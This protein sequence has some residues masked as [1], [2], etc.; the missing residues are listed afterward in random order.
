MVRRPTIRLSGPRQLLAQYFHQ[1]GLG[2]VVAV[3]DQTGTATGTQRFDAWGNILASTGTIPQYG[4]T[5]REPDE[6]GLVYYRARYY[7]PTIGRFT[8]RDPIGLQ[9][10][11]NQYAYVGGNPVNFADPFGERPLTGAEINFLTPIFHSSVDYSKVDIQNGANW[12]PIAGIAHLHGN[13]AITLNN[14]VYIAQDSNKYVDDFSNA[15]IG[16]QRLLVHEITHV[17]QKQN[18]PEYSEI[19]AGIEGLLQGADA[20]NYTLSPENPSI[21]AGPPKP[22]GLYGFE[23]QAQLVENGFVAT[24]GLSASESPIPNMEQTDYYNSHMSTMGTGGLGPWAS[25]SGS[26][27]L[28]TYNA[29]PAGG[30]SK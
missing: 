13:P 3:S 15:S 10:G 18:N 6:T 21:V 4:Y 30:R 2:S 26:Q 9:G 29:P 7:D 8:Q 5:G 16:S 14:T 17:W 20:Y 24:T 12:N 28:S 25:T 23:Q 27:S 1:D 22:L 19:K 11:I